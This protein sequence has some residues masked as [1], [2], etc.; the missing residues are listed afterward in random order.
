MYDVASYAQLDQEEFQ[1]PAVDTLPTLESILGEEE[2]GTSISQTQVRHQLTAAETSQH[3]GEWM[4]TLSIH[5]HL[6]WN[7]AIFITIPTGFQVI[8]ID[9]MLIL[10][11]CKI[12][13]LKYWNE[14]IL[15]C[16]N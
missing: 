2:P 8:N 4:R 9:M 14:S 6:H 5:V 1:L 13:L 7:I 12:L 15:Q 11:S 10:N 3:A 16:S